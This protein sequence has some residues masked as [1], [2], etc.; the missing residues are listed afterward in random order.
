MAVISAAEA[1]RSFSR[2]LREVAEGKS[3]TVL[4]RGRAVAT[5][6][7]PQQAATAYG[8]ARA[9]LL[10][11]LIHQVPGDGARAW[12]RDELYD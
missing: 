5:I 9:R 1:N 4:S 12:K 8:A 10:Q 3:F 7:A 2:L 6:S 11:R